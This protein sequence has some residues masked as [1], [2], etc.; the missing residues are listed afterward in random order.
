MADVKFFVHG[1]FFM[2]YNSSTGNLEILAPRIDKHHFVSG[3]V[4][5]RAEQ[6]D[7]TVLHFENSGLQRGQPQWPSGTH[8]IPLD[9]P[10]TI[11]Q[12]TQQDA[13]LGGFDM[14][15]PKN[16]VGKIILPWPLDFT[17]LRTSDLANTFPFVQ[18]KRPPLGE[19][20][21]NRSSTK[22]SK[23]VGIVTVLRYSTNASPPP[24]MHFYLQPCT[25]ETITDVNADLAQVANY[26][27]NHT[28]FNLEL[29]NVKIPVTSRGS[30][31]E[32]SLEEDV[33]P[34]ILAI[35]PLQ[36]KGT[37]KDHVSNQKSSTAGSDQG[38]P[39]VSPANCP[40]FFVGG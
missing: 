34:D 30:D 26:F 35:C 40:T 27:V 9:V 37:K 28:N 10:G 33:S 25:D 13:N 1:L 11:L 4:G 6:Q 18:G 5:L 20:I 16:F 8:D 36:P 3:P 12:F 39:A 38:Q 7:G 21:Q 29:Q 23:A 14:S 19:A 17:S 22:G 32:K 2:T 15:N 31:D 24:K